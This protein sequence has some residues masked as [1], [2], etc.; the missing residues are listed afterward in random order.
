VTVAAAD[1]GKA[2]A[3]EATFEKALYGLLDDRTEGPVVCW[4]PSLVL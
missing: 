4:Q 2:V 1:A 3:E